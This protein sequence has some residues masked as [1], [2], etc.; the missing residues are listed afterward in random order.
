MEIDR[1]SKRQLRVLKYSDARLNMLDGSVRSGKTVASMVAWLTYAG[2]EANDGDLMMVGK[3]ER[4]LKRNIIDPMTDLVGTKNL[5]Y[6]RGLGEMRLFNRRVHIMGAHDERS[7]EKIRGLTLA[8]AYIDEATLVPESFFKMLLSRLSVPGSK[9]YATMN[10]DSPFHWLKVQYLDREDELDMRRWQFRLDDNLTLDPRYIEALKE[11]YSGLWYQRF[12]DGLWVQAEGTIYDMFD[13][14][15]H[16]VKDIPHI[17]Q[18]WVGI[19]YGTANPQVYLLIGLGADQKLYV[20][21]EY[22]W[23]SRQ[24][25]RQKT[26]KEYSDDYLAWI[27]RYEWAPRPSRV[28]VD[29]TAASFTNQLWSDGVR[30]VSPGDAAVKDGIRAVA[31]L[32]K[33]GRLKIHESCEGLIK[34]MSSYVWDPQAQQRGEDKP[35]SEMDHAPDALRYC[36]L[37]IQPYWRHWLK[38]AA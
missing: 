30:G 12:I 27:K 7:Q 23:D 9:L 1:F 15:L 11:E 31:A 2:V 33:A 4:T 21:R 13:V 34:E 17:N 35:I 37:S 24:E 5:T 16:V 19:D 28:F 26:D 6:N 20:L 36:V 32:I 8:G 29:P 18:T 3:T 10:P 38:G 25:N 14:D 22:R